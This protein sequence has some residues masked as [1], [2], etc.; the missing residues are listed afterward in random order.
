MYHFTTSIASSDARWRRR[1]LQMVAYDPTQVKRQQTSILLGRRLK[2][3]KKHICV[4][5]TELWL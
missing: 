1:Q 5:F 3:T 2:F 4:S